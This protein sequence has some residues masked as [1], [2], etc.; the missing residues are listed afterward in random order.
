MIFTLRL[1]HFSSRL[2]HRVY[3]KHTKYS[4]DL[5]LAAE[6]IR[7]QKKTE[8]LVNL[9]DNRISTKTKRQTFY[10]SFCVCVCV[11]NIRSLLIFLRFSIRHSNGHWIRKATK[12][13]EA[14]NNRSELCPLKAFL[15]FFFF[16]LLSLLVASIQTVCSV[17]LYWFWPCPLN[18]TPTS[19]HHQIMMARIRFFRT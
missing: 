14:H 6:I 4:A 9:I 7:N 18:R 19:L 3:I 1:L 5:Q 15:L 17:W 13:I 16:Q 12:K 8:F 11:L 2:H 10:S